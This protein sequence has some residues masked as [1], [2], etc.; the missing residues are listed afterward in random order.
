GLKGT[1]L[2]LAIVKHIVELHGGEVSCESEM[3]RGSRF[4]FTLPISERKPS[5]SLSLPIVSQPTGQ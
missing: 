4:Y 2:G 1:G 3:G 5:G